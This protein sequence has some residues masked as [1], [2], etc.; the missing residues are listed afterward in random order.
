MSTDAATHQDLLADVRDELAKVIVGHDA[1]VDGLL[2][3]LIVGGHAL[4][5]G[6]PGTAKTL[7][8]TT[9]AAALDLDVR[10][11]QF[12]PDLMPSDL[13][14]RVIYRQETGR[15]TFHEGPLFTNLLIGDEI[16]R[17][18][19]K[20]QA[21]LLE[22]MQERQVTVEGHSHRLPDPFLVIATQNP[23]EYEGTY[24]LP[25]AQIDRFLVKLSVGYPEPEQERAMLGR[26]D[27]GFD[28]TDVSR[29]GVR[30]VA[31]SAAI[32]RA[33]AAATAVRVDERIISY[34]VDLARATRSSPSVRLGIS[35]RGLAMLLHT[36]KAWTL[37]H[38]G[39]F[40]TPDEV[41]AMCLPTWRHRLLLRPEVELEGATADNVLRNLLRATAVPR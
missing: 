11:V 19:P 3:A 4:L 39:E 23:V 22:A 31:D 5:E 38:G 13:I 8:A 26:H 2:V 18:P 40:V 10:R 20:T 1:V 16:N 30:A 29:A 24:P 15:F 21:A 36:S 17:T 12:T 32:E 14:G 28:A 34:L 41:Q 7:T 9:L 33:R 37:L 25:E 35:P 6:V 27:A